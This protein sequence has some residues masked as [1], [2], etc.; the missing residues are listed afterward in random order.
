[1]RLF[2]LQRCCVYLLAVLPLI[3]SAQFDETGTDRETKIF[4]GT[5]LAGWAGKEGWWYVEDGAITSESTPEKPCRKCNYLIWQGGEPADFELNLD[6]KLS[7]RGNSG[8][9]IRSRRVGNWDT[10]GYQADMSGDC[11]LVGFVYH[12]KRGLIAGRG[13]DVTINADGSRVVR[14]FGDP[15]E[16]IKAYKPEG[17]NHYRIVCRGPQIQLFINRTLMCRFEDNSTDNGADG[18]I[19]AL[20]MHPGPSMKVQF[21]NIFLKRPRKAGNRSRKVESHATL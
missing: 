7:S 1:M 2:S 4:N 16:L 20:Q 8:I 21:K 10:F 5:D 11:K 17:W 15:A 9:Q 13:E 18:G 3:V 14:K 19:I 12:H 6:F